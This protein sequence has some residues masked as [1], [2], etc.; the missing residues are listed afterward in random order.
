MPSLPLGWAYLD[1]TNLLLALLNRD[2]LFSGRERLV[3]RQDEYDRMLAEC[4]DAEVL[5]RV[6]EDQAGPIRVDAPADPPYFLRSDA[7]HHRQVPCLLRRRLR[8]LLA[9][10]ATGLTELGLSLV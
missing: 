6:F 4:P 3:V 7:V 5:R 10:P 8:G 2:S 9:A 1:V